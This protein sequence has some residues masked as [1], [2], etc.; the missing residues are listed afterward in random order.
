MTKFAKDYYIFDEKFAF[1]DSEMGLH[2]VSYFEAK[3]R[4]NLG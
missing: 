2:F 1:L 3:F 4:L